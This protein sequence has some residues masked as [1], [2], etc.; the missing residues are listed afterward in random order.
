MDAIV[1]RL[2]IAGSS[3][4]YSYRA[5][6]PLAHVHAARRTRCIVIQAPLEGRR[7]PSTRLA[8]VIAPDAWFERELAISCGLA[9]R[10][11][12]VAR[13]IEAILIRTIYPEMT[14]HLTP[15]TLALDDD[16]PN[17]SHRV[18][19]FDLNAAFDR[20]APE[21]ETLTAADLGLF[22]GHDLRAA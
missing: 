6:V 5:L 3:P 4:R 11:S 13:R 2:R 18:A 15:L 14:G 10:L 8:D 1:S 19:V 9:A 21:I 22:P 16:T 20:L 7:I 12:L 17:A